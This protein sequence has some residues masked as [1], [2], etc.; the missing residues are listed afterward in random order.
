MAEPGV[1]DQAWSTW[2]RPRASPAEQRRDVWIAGVVLAGAVVATVLTNSMG[3]FALGKAPALWEQLAWAAALTVPLVVRRRFPLVVLIVVGAVFIAAQ[4]RRVGDNVMPSVA[5]FIAIYTVGAWEQ[6][7]TWARWSRIGVIVAMFAWLVYN[8]FT[9]MGRGTSPFEGASGPLNPMLAAVIYGIAY[10][11]MY[12]LGA[13]F[14]G[15]VAWL[16]ARRRA[17]LVQRAEELRLSQEQNTRGAIVAER[18]RIA[19]DLHDVV[20]HYVSVMGV[21]AGAARRVFTKDP[22]VASEA[23]RTVERT[24]RTAINEL[25]GLLGVLRAEDTEVPRTHQA[26]PG[27]DQLPELVTAARNAGVDVAHGVYGEPRPVP[28]GVALSAYRV[29]QE[30]LTNVVKHAGARTADVR[31][32]FLDTA[33]EVEVTDDGRGGAR[34]DAVT[35]SS[36]FGLLGMRE[37]VAVHGGEL[38]AGPRRDGGYRV[39]VSLP[40]G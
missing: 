22:E 33:L 25:R 31:V 28:Q 36:G 4:A 9:A 6:N 29:V 39:R 17:E 11:L 3:A 23:L 32:R 18:V 10:N 2:R 15:H 38:E 7:R 37:R 30:A 20:A 5:L 34:A 8:M 14:F 16:S 35:G 40:T 26:S 19:R 27:L 13:Y 12:F 24:A 21:Q 1:D